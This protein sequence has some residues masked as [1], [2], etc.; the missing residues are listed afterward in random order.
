M[1]KIKK[2]LIFLLH[3]FIIYNI[4]TER[5][6]IRMQINKKIGYKAAIFDLD[7]TI[8][9]T[10]PD[11]SASVN[12][13]LSEKGYACRTDGE[14][15]RNINGGV[16]ELIRGAL[17][18]GVKDDNAEL[19]RCVEVYDRYYSSH[20]CDMTKLYDGLYEV[21]TELNRQGIKLAVYTNKETPQA[22]DIIENLIPG[23]FD[24]VLGSGHFPL[25]PEPVGTLW[26]LGQLGACADDVLF[27]GDSVVDVHTAHN[28]DLRVA[29]VSWG[30]QGSERLIAEGAD[31]IIDN[32]NQIKDI[33]IG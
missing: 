24:I 31:Y 30:Y 28:A 5:K 19:E 9:N 6:D 12:A 7:G 15:L 26:L 17:P 33:V 3:Y 18:D 22:A 8:A 11:I 21:L 27:V 32:A 1:N 14:I 23:V 4:L 13:M 2:L 10:F 29:G 16:Y 20:Y 25:K